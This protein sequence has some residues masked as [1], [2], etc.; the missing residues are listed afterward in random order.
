MELPVG[1]EGQVAEVHEPSVAS[2]LAGVVRDVHVLLQQEIALGAQELREEVDSALSS[3]VRI[4]A[5]G[6]V[7]ALGVG[8]LALGAALA[9][10]GVAGWPPWAGFVAV[11]GGL[12]VVGLTAFW[13]QTRVRS[14]RG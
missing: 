7:G 6:V 10:P 4:A 11:G 9:L 8:F 3:A 13:R 1:Q 14:M 5:T 12:G 2:L